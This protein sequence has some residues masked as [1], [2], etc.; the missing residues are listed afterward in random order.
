MTT[1]T[2]RDLFEVINSHR[3]SEIIATFDP[4]EMQPEDLELLE[5]KGYVFDPV[6]GVA[7]QLEDDY[8]AAL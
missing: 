4:M 1:A 7:V 6:D 2:P 8:N 3:P 5:L